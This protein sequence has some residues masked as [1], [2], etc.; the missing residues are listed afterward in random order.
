MLSAAAAVVAIAL[1]GGCV[2]QEPVVTP[3]PEPSSTPVFASDEEAL[4][5][6]TDAYARYLKVADG[7]FSRGGEGASELETV[8][9]GHQLDVEQ[10]GF[11]A[12]VAQGLHSTG[13]TVFDGVELQ[14]Y[15][16]ASLGESVV[17][18]YLCEDISGV[19]VLDRSGNSVKAHDLRSRSLY[20]VTFDLADGDSILKVSNKQPWS[21]DEC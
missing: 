11:A 17:V 15:D 21:S 7:I 20:E 4:A 13:S 8:V 3:Q 18:V 12:A 2:P 6:A 14:Q 9:T 1:L 5:A 19:D 10:E 16:R